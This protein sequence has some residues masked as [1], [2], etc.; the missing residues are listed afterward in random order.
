MLI[1]HPHDLELDAATGAKLTPSTN[2][3]RITYVL[4]D[5]LGAGGMSVI[6]RARRKSPQGESLAVVKLLLP[7]FVMESQ[8]VA[9]TSITKEAS[10]LSLLND[11]VPP[12]PF[13]VRFYDFGFQK[14]RFG[15]TVL[16]LPWLALEF[17]QGGVLGTT[18]TERVQLACK[19]GGVAFDMAR[20][21]RAIE[22]LCQG[23]S[24]VHETGVIHRD[25]KPDNVLCCGFD[26]SEIFKITDFGIARTNALKAT[27]G[28]LPMGTPGY[29]PLE[30]VDPKGRN[31]GP[32]TD[33][34]ALAAISYF[35][36][37][38]E[39]LFDTQNLY[40]A[41]LK[42]DDPSRRSIREGRFLDPELRRSTFRC[43]GIDEVIARATAA[44]PE[45]RPR[46]AR[47]LASLLRP[48]LVTDSGRFSNRRPPPV[49]PNDDTV[50]VG[51]QWG[52][53][54]EPGENRIVRHVSWN[55]DGTALV[56]TTEGLAYWTGT[57][58]QNVPLSGYPNPNGLR[59]IHKIGANHWLLGGDG[60]TLATLTAHGLTEVIQ[61]QDPR[62]VLEHASGDP[63]DL[64]LMVAAI[65]DSPPLL[66]GMAA[67]RWLRPMP[68][69][70]VSMVT[71]LARVGDE[72]WL[73]VGRT[74]N[75]RGFAAFYEPTQWRL[76]P[77]SVPDITAFLACAGLPVLA[78]GV[79][80]G[81]N[82]AVL[83]YQDGQFLTESVPGGDD[84]SAVAFSP[85][86]QLWA[87]SAGRIYH[88]RLG[89]HHPW[90]CLWDHADWRS[91]LI[92]LQAD[93][94][95]IRAMSVDGGLLESRIP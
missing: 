76:T 88:R 50:L 58:W 9:I 31:V 36:L 49:V 91:P 77:L 32:W 5:K 65:P 12:T 87:C 39:H 72:H 52:V 64:A 23:M 51:P 69:E 83:I 35:L 78:A 61:G 24:A 93:V 38:G 62:M 70:G 11:Q 6:F 86:K 59:F 16:S 13:V 94:G 26:D 92:S 27:F 2:Q 71:S 54:H 95:L 47:E 84:L 14:V 43:D 1:I 4:D 30:Q 28:G 44:K 25:M 63:S 34:F 80:V 22:H 37:T 85:T 73:V 10:S 79:A 41:I 82:G 75:D 18:L 89:S 20:A 68:L 66:W 45:Y 74:T 21:A 57:D 33:V 8:E 19:H 81:T 90:V 46:S 53:L 42:L 56:V 55:G 7:K 48:H 29:A 17:I 60:A 40:S 15:A 67:R 3:R